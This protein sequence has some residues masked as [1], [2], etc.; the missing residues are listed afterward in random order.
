MM[1]VFSQSSP[2]QPVQKPFV[3]ACIMG[4][5]G[6]NLFEVAAASALAWDHH[7]VPRFSQITP[8]AV[9]EHVFFRCPIVPALPAIASTYKEPAFSYQPIPF[10]PNMA[11]NGYFQSEKYFARY[12]KRLLKLFA[13]RADDLAYIKRKY[14]KI[15]RHSKTVG[16][17]I[18]YYEIEDP[19]SKF[20]PQYGKDYLEKAM[21]R[22]PKSSLFVVSS[23]NIEYA[24]NNLPKWAK[25]VVFLQNEP[26][27]IDLHIL[28]MCKHNIITNSSFGWWGAW[29]NKN[30]KKIVVYP[31]LIF[32]GLPTQ[33]FAPSRWVGIDAVPEVV[34]NGT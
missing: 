10:T 27:Y 3:T 19:Q 26:N 6:N 30:H 20:F 17:Q 15:L 16:V 4:Q 5:L 8:A 1:P 14:K 34:P 24:R 33:D 13:P 2:P 22:F 7:A 31:K 18:R 21:S 12:R 32:Y 29:L 11:I 9:A 28:S 25:K 23:N